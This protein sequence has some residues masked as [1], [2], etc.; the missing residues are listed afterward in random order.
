M[1]EDV[2]C[3]MCERDRLADARWDVVAPV[4]DH[5]ER[6]SFEAAQLGP[7]CN[8]PVA[9]TPGFTDSYRGPVAA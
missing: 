7:A 2:T 3:P 6:A 5:D 8:Q 4:P 1:C 9:K